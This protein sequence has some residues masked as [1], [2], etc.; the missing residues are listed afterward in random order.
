MII[1]I[2]NWVEELKRLHSEFDEGCVHN[3]GHLIE[4]ALYYS[5]LIIRKFSET[6][7]AKRDFLGPHMKGRAYAL[8]GGAIDG[9]S[10]LNARSH[11]DF[12]QG[13]A[14]QISLTDICNILIHSKFLEWRP[15]SGQVKEILVAAGIK[16]GIQAVG[17]APAQFKKMLLRVEQ[18]KFKKFPLRPARR[19]A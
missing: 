8:T 7:F 16:S 6:P 19:V 12:D 17:F 13:T 11:F 10:W 1:H 15:G 14:A 4:R 9:L 5:A 2:D 18:Y 3:D